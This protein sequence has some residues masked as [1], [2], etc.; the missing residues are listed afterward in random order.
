MANRRRSL[1]KRESR[2]IIDDFSS[3]FGLPYASNSTSLTTEKTMQLSAVYRCVDVVTDGAACMPINVTRF[4]EKEGWTVDIKHPHHNLLNLSPN[5]MMTR[6][7][8]IKTLVTK[9]LLD[10]NGYARIHRDG[11]G[12]PIR[13]ELI[14][15]T[16]TVYKL[17]DGSGLV[18]RI[19]KGDASGDYEVID[20]E[21]MIHILNFTY[22]GCIGVSTLTHAA[23]T[24]SLADSAEKQ[25]KGFF[26]G[27]AN[28]SGVLKV[29]GKITPEK[30]AAMKTAWSSAFETAEG[31][32]AGVAVIEAGTEFQPVTVNPKDAQMLESRQFSV[33][34]ICRF[35]GVD[36]SKAFD[37][38]GRSYN[39]VEA[40]QL[41]FLTDTMQSLVAKIENEFNR[42]LWRPS[43]KSVTKV[44]FDTDELLRTDSDSQANYMMKMFQIGAY[45]SNE[46]RMRIG[47]TKVEGG[48]IPYVQVNMQPLKTGASLVVDPVE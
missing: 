10:G 11:S 26:T 25:A 9:V 33:V 32:P 16:V 41:A 19:S 14:V 39:S 2:S 35:F 3:Y 4:S 45:T 1:F 21:D 20:G 36:P 5:P 8:F 42:K 7:T 31:A 12:N 38:N 18:Y 15:T 43:E 22:D 6:F 37:T 34:E 40:G 47:N 46:V 24:T 44:R 17:T 13:L 48:D 28:L 29:A 30:A 23:Q 27:G